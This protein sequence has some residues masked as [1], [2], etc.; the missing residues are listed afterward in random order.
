[1]KMKANDP[2]RSALLADLDEAEQQV[3]EASQALDVSSKQG[4]DI[5]LAKLAHGKISAA[6]DALVRRQLHREARECD[7]RDG[8]RANGGATAASELHAAESRHA[9]SRLLRR[10]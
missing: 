10:C 9:M 3:D 4:G 6:A 8:Y 7:S 1:M 2:Q 5:A